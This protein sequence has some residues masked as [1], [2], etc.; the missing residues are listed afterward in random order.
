MRS[1][2]PTFGI[3]GSVAKS[4]DSFSDIFP[5]SLVHMSPNIFGK[6]TM[7]KKIISKISSLRFLF[8]SVVLTFLDVKSFTQSEKHISDNLLYDC[9][10]SEN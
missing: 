5:C 10:K 6:I 2:W 8:T 4:V 9:K 3:L 1:H 7:M